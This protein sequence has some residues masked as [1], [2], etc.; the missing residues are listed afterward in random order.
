MSSKHSYTLPKGQATVLVDMLQQG[1]APVDRAVMG[2]LQE[3]LTHQ[4]MVGVYLIQGDIFRWC[5]RIYA[6]NFGYL[7]EDI[8]GHPVAKVAAP[9][10]LPTIAE[11]LRMRESGEIH[12]V[13]YLNKGRHRSGR[14]VYFEVQGM[15]VMFEGQP[16]VAGVS[17]DVTQHVLNERELKRSREQLQDLARHTNELR[18]MQ[19]TEV[20]RE[21]HDVLGGILTSLKMDAARLARRIDPSLLEQVNAM[22]ALA[23][24]GIDEVHR[25]SQH[26]RSAV[27]DHLG[28]RAAVTEGLREFGQRS[29]LRTMLHAH[30][31][32]PSLNAKNR[33]SVFRIFQEALTNILRH[34]KA[35]RVDVTLQPDAKGLRLRVVDDGVGI[36]P[37]QAEAAHALGLLGMRERARQMGGTLN[38]CGLKKGTLVDLWVPN[39]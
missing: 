26:L 37:E 6:Q 22:A 18:E 33:A 2:V 32:E 38:V 10:A 31:T 13:R 25:I 36:T 35:H 4:A 14:T 15:R 5:N 29:G 11:Y 12:S 9:T 1:D 39:D 23:Q 27:L 21:L 3:A 24:E 30:P 17:V 20:A 19:R 16:A 8:I 28:L 7:P 34:A